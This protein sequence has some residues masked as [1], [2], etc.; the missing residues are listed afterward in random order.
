MFCNCG[1]EID[2]TAVDCP[3][4]GASVSDIDS[5]E[6]SGIEFTPGAVV[7][8]KYEILRLLGRGGMGQV[9]LAKDRQ[10]ERLIALKT[11]SRDFN[12][13]E[14]YKA[15]FMRE[16]RMASALNHPNILTVYEVGS[17]DE[18][19]FI[20]TEYVEGQTLR[21]IMDTRPL[22]LNDALEVAI[23]VARGLSAAH[24]AGIIHRDLK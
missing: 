21:Q 1:A 6:N 8:D 16:A 15:R 18:T 23:Q 3:N 13:D 11:L 7:L 2:A 17:I 12:S 19:L 24:E 14:E 9:Y 4:C 20:A 5:E 10:L 22:G